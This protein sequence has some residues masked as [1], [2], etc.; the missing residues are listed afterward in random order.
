[1]LM[2]SYF[3]DLNKDDIDER[4]HERTKESVLAFESYDPQ[5][6][7]FSQVAVACTTSIPALRWKAG[8]RFL[9]KFMMIKRS[10][11]PEVQRLHWPSRIH[12]DLLEQIRLWFYVAS[13]L[14]E[15]SRW[16]LIARETQ[17]NIMHVKQ[18]F[19]I[20]NLRYHW[21]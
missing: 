15:R 18:R 21:Q 5:M 16:V 19:S 2:L 3:L 8:L 10:V 6:S 1:M 4:L 11:R 9:A 17:L 7:R 13:Q 12:R 20:L 14:R